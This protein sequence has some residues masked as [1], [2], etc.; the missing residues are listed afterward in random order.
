M[1]FQCGIVGLPNVGGRAL[2][3]HGGALTLNAKLMWMNVGGERW[4]VRGEE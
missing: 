2:R 4:G 3:R 1:G